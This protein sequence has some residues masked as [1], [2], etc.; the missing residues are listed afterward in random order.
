MVN[1]IPTH[2]N[3]HAWS[4]MTFYD[5]KTHRE[6]ILLNSFLFKTDLRYLAIF[7][8][9]NEEDFLTTAAGVKNVSSELVCNSM[10]K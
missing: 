3:G 6:K 7:S 8:V 5:P 1:I 9:L 10:W 4:R 2:V